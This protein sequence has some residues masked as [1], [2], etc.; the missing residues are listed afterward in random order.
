MRI[1]ESKCFSWHGF[2][3]LLQ[4]ITRFLGGRDVQGVEVPTG[5]ARLAS[6][7]SSNQHNWRTLRAATPRARAARSS[8]SHLQKHSD[9]SRTGKREKFP[10]CRARRS[11][12][13]PLGRVGQR[14]TKDF[15]VQLFDPLLERAQ[16]EGQAV[17]FRPAFLQSRPLIYA[18]DMQTRC[19]YTAFT[20]SACVCMLWTLHL[21]SV[22]QSLH[23]DDSKDYVEKVPCVPQCPFPCSVM[24]EAWKEEFVL[25]FHFLLKV[26]ALFELYL[27]SHLADDVSLGFFFSESNTCV[28]SYRHKLLYWEMARNSVRGG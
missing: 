8:P 22:L 2:C 13:L 23:R 27:F 19:C 15:W 5:Q 20:H 6:G 4:S 11:C 9:I 24:M 1:S 28:C 7:T 21:L 12:D 16:L 25:H 14:K 3:L 10:P 26:C 18:A 17:P